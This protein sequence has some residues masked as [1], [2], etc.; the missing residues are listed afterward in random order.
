MV[1]AWNIRSLRQYDWLTLLLRELGM[2][3]IEMAALLKVR[4]PGSSR[5]SVGGYT[6]LSGHHPQGVAIA[7]CSTLQPSVVE[8]I[9]VD[10][11][12]MVLRQK[13]AFCFT[14]LIAMY[15]PNNACKLD[16]KEM[17]YAK[18]ASV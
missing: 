13:I 8:V 16:M 11:H 18:L 2:L 4:R 15:A 7:I 14:S 5:I 1:G 3:R 17:V 9:P 10:E 12:L 6:A